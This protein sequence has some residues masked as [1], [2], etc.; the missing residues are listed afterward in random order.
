MFTVT[1]MRGL[2]FLPFENSTLLPSLQRVADLVPQWDVRAAMQHVGAA[3]V[4]LGARF[5]DETVL[6]MSLAFAVQHERILH[7]R[8]VQCDGDTLAWLQSRP[9][10][11]AAVALG[12]QLLPALEPDVFPHECAAIAMQLLAGSGERGSFHDLVLDVTFV[13]LIAALLGHIAAAYGVPTIADDQ[14]LRSGLEAHVI[15]ACMRQRFGLWAPQTALFADATDQW[16]VERGIADQLATIV[17]EHTGYVLPL[18]ERHNLVLLVRATAIRER[19]AHPEHVLVVCPSGMA[20]TQLLVARLRVRF[21]HL[22]DFEVLSL[23]DLSLE[24]I[25]TASLIITTIPLRLP[26]DATIDVIEVHPLL[27]QPDIDAIRQWIADNVENGPHL[28]T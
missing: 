26:P 8:F 4:A 14:T 13:K 19:P 23:R 10:W 6:Q 9:I 12:E 15:P 2:V 7:R 17:A 25:A 28:P 20:T 1:H 5:T 27:R 18:S 21:P 3:E 16:T 22:G 24:R 11:S